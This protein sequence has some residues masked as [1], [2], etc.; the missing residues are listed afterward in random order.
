MKTLR[1]YQEEC[2]GEIKETFEKSNFQLVQLPTGSGKTVIFWELL[3]RHYKKALIIVP[4]IQ[5]MEQCYEEGLNYFSKKD[6]SRKGDKYNEKIKSFHIV[7]AYSLNK[8]YLSLL[9]QNEFEVIICDEAHRGVS[10]TYVNFFE[11]YLT[12]FPKTQILGMTATP[13][14]K[15]CKGL[16]AIFGTLSYKKELYDL[17]GE[18]FLSELRGIKIKT[19]LEILNAINYKGDFTSASIYR[20]LNSS[21]RD[22]II[23]EAYQNHCAHRKTLVFCLSVAH[24]ISVANLFVHNGI[25]AKCVHGKMSIAERR[26]ILQRFRDGSVDVLTN[27]QLLTEGFDEPSIDALIIARPTKSKALY[28]QMVGRGVRLYEGKEDCLVVD[29][30]DNH[31]QLCNFSVLAKLNEPAL[32]EEYPDF[33]LLGDL[34]RN[35]S[36][37]EAA[38]ISSQEER[39]NFFSDIVHNHWKENSAPLFLK[40]KLQEANIQFFDPITIEEAHFLIHYEY[41]KGKYNGKH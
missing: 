30:A 20:A 37:I 40:E 16:L 23:L 19:N 6:L 2:L 26:K 33:V 21:T 13:E 24:S 5:L 39:M 38:V 35:P 3:K 9:L 15:D 17:I 28:T 8:S 7:V 18:G 11:K 36:L 12:S 25:K 14:R 31:H 41:L 34:I 29:I 1:D 4:S 10:S 32:N 27:C 22:H